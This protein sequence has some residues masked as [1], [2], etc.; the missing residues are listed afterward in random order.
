M[1]GPWLLV[2][3]DMMNSDKEPRGH[4]LAECLG[5]V[6]EHEQEINCGSMNREANRISCFASLV[7]H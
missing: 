2:F 7:V 3:S 5:N 4:L 1:V 6:H